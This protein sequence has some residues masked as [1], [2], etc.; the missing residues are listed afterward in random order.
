MRLD[1]CFSKLENISRKLFFILF[2]IFLTGFSAVSLLFTTYYGS[3]Y[4]ERPLYSSDKFILLI[5]IF[6]LVI[7]ALFI[8]DKRFGIEKI[9]TGRLRMALMI[10]TIVVGIFWVFTS[11]NTIG[12][13]QKS[14]SE[15]ASQFCDNNFSGLKEGGYL[16]IYP[17]QLGMTAFLEVVYRISGKG[18]YTV[19]QL[20]N[21]LF[22]CVSFFAMY[23]I[24]DIF[25]KKNKV[26]NILLILLFGC[27]PPILYC[28]FVYGN[29][30]SMML[31]LISVWMQL[32]YLESGRTRYFI[33]SA[34]SISLAVIIKSNS[35]IVL[36]AMVIMFIMDFIR[37]RRLRQLG[38]SAVLVF[39]VFMSGVW[40]NTFYEKRSGIEINEGA[41]KILWA[42]MG[43]QEGNLAPG[44]YNKYT[45]NTYTQSDYDEGKAI[46]QAEESI[47]NSLE[48]FI[49]NPAYAA[50]FFY[51]KFVSQWNDPTYEGFWISG[52]HY[53]NSS[54]QLLNSIY[55]G[56]IH[57]ISAAFM[58][59][60]QFII[61]FGALCFVILERK[62]IGANEMFLAM[63]IFGGFLFHMIW[64]AKGQY[65]MT[66]FVM[67]IPYS[68]AGVNAV[69]E[70]A[71][72]K[73]S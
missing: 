44:W 17:F 31:C 50:E 22:L 71:K 32:H 15:L 62:R 10:Y 34:L 21:V 14:V 38:L 1:T 69:L 45:L 39:T 65:I 53:R 47:N 28:T 4:A 51:E 13:D 2:G 55:Y 37:K 3:N 29:I 30:M 41:P 42:A 68:A 16:L 72:R 67:L 33:I 64:E 59:S 9:N 46:N 24:T 40:L 18:N 66:Y 11:C 8:F 27:F 73:A 60:Y 49:E 5:I 23:K 61:I 25:F 36:A 12:A 54:D 63:I 52:V 7:S 48:A 56:N 43:L 19:F 6:I 20:L 35:L 58:N 57:S 26:N 70:L